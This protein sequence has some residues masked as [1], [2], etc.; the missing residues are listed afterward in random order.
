MAV[1]GEFFF[2]AYVIAVFSDPSAVLSLLLRGK[3]ASRARALQGDHLVHYQSP[4][5]P[6]IEESITWHL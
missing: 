2:T 1:S 4:Q 5:S 3:D 6:Q